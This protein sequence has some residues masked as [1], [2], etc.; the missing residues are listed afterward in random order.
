MTQSK[1][2]V[3]LTKGA[4]WEFGIRRTVPVAPAAAW[5]F[6]TGPGLPMWLGVEELGEAGSAY[7]GPTG[8]GEVRSRTPGVRIRVTH[9]SAAA[10]PETTIQVSLRSV[11]TGTT[12]AFHQERLID[13]EARERARR[14]WNDVV[15]EVV[16]ALSV[17]TSGRGR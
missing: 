4:G 10:A 3:G 6:L 11:A 5:E 17:G 12:I 7:D 9:R 8:S 15:D 14:H 13:A 2:F 16:D 1:P